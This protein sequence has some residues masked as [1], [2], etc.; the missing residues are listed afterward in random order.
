MIKKVDPELIEF[1]ESILDIGF[2][3]KP[4]YCKLKNILMKI[5]H[6]ETKVLDNSILPTTKDRALRVPVFRHN[7][8]F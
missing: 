5:M 3:E 2:D 1:C 8:R 7:T 6:K 4:N